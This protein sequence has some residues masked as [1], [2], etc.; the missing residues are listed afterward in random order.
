[1][2]KATGVVL[3]GGRSRRF[4]GG[5][6]ALATLDGDPLLVH[7]VRALAA[8]ADGVVVN[9]RA[10]QRPSFEAALAAADLDGPVSF[11][12]D[13]RPDEGPLAGLVRAFGVIDTEYAVVLA[14]DM[15]LVPASSLT[16]LLERAADAGTA[17]VPRTTGGLEPTCAVYR[18]GR[19]RSA[20]ETAYTDGERSLHALL[21]RLSPT[22]V[23]ISA[24]GLDERSLT[25]VDTV[26]T[27]A[28]LR[29]ASRG[30]H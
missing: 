3:A 28:R 8:V 21:Q 10:D 30:N 25:S 13:D 26:E 27:L 16:A 23:D 29:G 6:K 5:D 14:C 19:G 9:C 17:V 20:A 1:M 2:T 24:V 11:A 7:V 18:V 4:A 22:V 15:P 12:V